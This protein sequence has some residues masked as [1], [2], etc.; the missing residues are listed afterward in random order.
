MDNSYRHSS[1]RVSLGFTLTE[2]LVAVAMGAML[3]A[4]VAGIFSLATQAVSG[5]Q[6]STDVNNQLRVLR[7]WLDR[8]FGRIRLDGPLV[9]IPQDTNYQLSD[10]SLARLDQIAF[11]ASG[12]FV[13][14]TTQATPNFSAPL[15]WIVYG[16]DNTVGTLLPPANPTTKEM[17][18]LVLA[19]WATLMVGDGTASGDVTTA[20]FADVL[21]AWPTNAW[22]SATGTRPVLTTVPFARMLNNVLSFKIVRYGIYDNNGVF[23]N[24]VVDMTTPLIDLVFDPAEPKPAWIEFE[25]AMRDSHNQLTEDHV[26]TY[27]VN[28]PS[29]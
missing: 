4:A 24:V 20:S 21:A 15:A 19:R 6:A 18:A 7:S 16:Q 13:S 9:I 1:S 25:I 8:D 10:G 22:R 11:L 5:S 27:R 26:S 17:S 29:R 23:R 3:V 28:L 12:R 2:M 14:M